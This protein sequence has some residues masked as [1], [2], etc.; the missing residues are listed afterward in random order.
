MTDKHL[1]TLIVCAGII[2]LG[3]MCLLAPRKIQAYASAR[4]ALFPFINALNQSKLY[5]VG[6]R[7]CGVLIIAMSC[8]FLWLEFFSH[9]VKQ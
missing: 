5:I 1:A 8:T 4:P 9:L 3:A 2:F 7:L 6:L